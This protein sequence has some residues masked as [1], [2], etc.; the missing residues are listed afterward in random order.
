[1]EKY[2]NKE[3]NFISVFKQISNIVKK[4]KYYN[5]LVHNI[6]IKNPILNKKNIK[7]LYKKII[8]EKNK[9]P[10]ENEVDRV[11]AISHSKSKKTCNNKDILKIPYSKEIFSK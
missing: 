1:M 2:I 4:N 7:E 3:N 6:T 11:R 5:Y 8:S 9:I 10:E